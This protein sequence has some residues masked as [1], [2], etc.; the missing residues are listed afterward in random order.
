MIIWGN[1]FKIGIPDIDSE[2]LIL[3]S[4]L[5]QIDINIEQKDGA[6]CLDDVIGAVQK[7]IGFHFSQEEQM[8]YDTLYP[9]WDEHCHQHRAFS[10]KIQQIHRNTMFEKNGVEAYVQLRKYIQEWFIS[11]ILTVD[12]EFALWL[13]TRTSTHDNLKSFELADGI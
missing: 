7:Y 13:S 3:F 1:D 8:M 12:R 4:L 5:N 6:D 9:K 2:H 11:H 10:E